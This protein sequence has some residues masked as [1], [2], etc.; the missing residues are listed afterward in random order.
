VAEIWREGPGKVGGGILPID[1]RELV[2][3]ERVHHD[4]G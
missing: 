3:A 2:P 4:W 1:R